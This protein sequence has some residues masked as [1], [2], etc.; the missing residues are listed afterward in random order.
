MDT[1]TAVDYQRLCD[2][3]A[4]MEDLRGLLNGV[5]DL[6]AASMTNRAGVRVECAV[7]LH[8]R[9]RPATAGGSDD[10][11][12]MLGSEGQRVGG[13]GLAAIRTGKPAVVNSPA[14]ISWS[15]FAQELSAS[16]FDSALAIPLDLGPSASA[17]INLFAVR[18]GIFTE[19]TIRDGQQF[20]DMAARALRMGLRIAEAEL[21]ASDLD[22]A[23]THR[24]V[25]NMAQGIIMAENRCSDEQAFTVLKK[26][27]STRNQKLHEVARAV[28]G[29]ITD[30]IPH[31]YFEH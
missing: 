4:Q 28:V 3:V 8:R 25:I 9:R 30:V 17:A 11:A 18:P 12:V 14:E 31:T 1:G 19:E 2:L 6:T 7:T 16:S 24:T 22:A 29:G 26:A 27:S 13:P 20:A 21:K 15:A 23:M 10:E 5:T